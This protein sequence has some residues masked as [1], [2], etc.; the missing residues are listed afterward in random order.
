MQPLTEDHT[1]VEVRS[2]DRPPSDSKAIWGAAGRAQFHENCWQVLLRAIAPRYKGPDQ[3][4]AA[5]RRCVK[6]AAARA[7]HH[8]TPLGARVTNIRP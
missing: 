6:E 2:G 3:L 8:D 5:E 7:E 1:V 4:S